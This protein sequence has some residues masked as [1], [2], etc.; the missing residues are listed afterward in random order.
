MQLVLN[1]FDEFTMLD[2]K[3]FAPYMSFN[4]EEVRRLCIRY[5]RDFS[6]VKRWYG[7]YLLSGMKIYNPKAIVSIMTWS[8]FQSYW[9]QTGT[10]ESV[11]LLI[12]M[13]FDGLNT[14]VIDIIAGSLVRINPET[15]QNDMVSLKN[16]D[17]VLMLLI[18]LGYLAYN[19]LNKTTFI[20]NE[21]IRQEMIDTVNENQYFRFS[22]FWIV[23][24]QK[25]QK[26]PLNEV[27]FCSSLKL[28]FS[29]Q[30]S[31]S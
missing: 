9:F 1:H 29:L 21:D 22:G 18:H 7:G 2:A 17:D 3:I 11:V 13:N 16:K 20:P 12:S 4:E 27:D 28:I 31:V 19:S 30:H 23:C 5:N 10:Y 8:D 26:S 24:L 6:E 25:E 15:C 14:A